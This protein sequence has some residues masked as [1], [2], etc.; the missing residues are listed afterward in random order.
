V[1]KHFLLIL[2]FQAGE[3]LATLVCNVA[4][5]ERNIGQKLKN[6]PCFK[7]LMPQGEINSLLSSFKCFLVVKHFG[8]W[9]W[10]NGQG[11]GF[12]TKEDC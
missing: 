5:W 7:S 12:S 9:W 4:K 1:G 8:P 3:N 11:L 2:Q 6:G 10:R